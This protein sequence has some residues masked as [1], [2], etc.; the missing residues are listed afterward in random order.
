MRALADR[1]RQIAGSE[2]A[3]ELFPR[4]AKRVEAQVRDMN[5]DSET[6]SKAKKTADVTRQLG[7]FLVR[8]SFNPKASTT[9]AD[10]FKLNQ[11]SGT[12]THNMVKTIGRVL[13]KSFRPWEAVKWTRWLANAGRVLQVVG[14]FLTVMLQTKEDADAAKL[15]SDLRESRVAV[16]AG[17][18][19][20]AYEIELHFDKATGAYVD[21]TI[22]QRLTEVDKQIK[23]L[24][25]LR[26]SRGN[27]FQELDGLLD[28]TR[29]LI[30]E[31]HSL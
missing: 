1:V 10:L 8:H 25:S 5:I 19:D 24:S 6:L 20:A 22:G 12:T 9:F 28:E 21:Q 26:Q 23:E 18:D 27:L 4:L 3:K 31:M 16:R 15:E 7:E 11:Y 30:S 2:L 17:F 13:G 29:G 14:V